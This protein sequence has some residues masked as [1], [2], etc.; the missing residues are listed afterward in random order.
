M[1]YN[2]ARES[3]PIIEE[4]KDWRERCVKSIFLLSSRLDEVGEHANRDGI[5]EDDNFD[6]FDSTYQEFFRAAEAAE[7]LLKESDGFESAFDIVAE[8]NADSLFPVDLL[9]HPLSK[10]KTA[11]ECHQVVLRDLIGISKYFL[12][13]YPV[14]DIPFR[15][16]QIQEIHD[17]FSESSKTISNATDALTITNISEIAD[18][19]YIRTKRYLSEFQKRG[20]LQEGNEGQSES[21]N[22]ANSQKIILPQNPDVVELIRRLTNKPVDMSDNEIARQFVGNTGAKWSSLLSQAKKKK[23]KPLW[24]SLK[25]TS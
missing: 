21:A 12:L 25:S 18:I 9:F 22:R 2:G 20:N 11:H 7:L 14:D 8:A 23:F 17:L 1:D 3:Q 10:P 13:D 5:T 6:S 15:D 19:E 24:D 16:D 4:A